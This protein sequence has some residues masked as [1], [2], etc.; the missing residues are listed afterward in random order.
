MSVFWKPL[1]QLKVWKWLPSSY[2]PYLVFSKPCLHMKYQI[3]LV[4]KCS[5][6]YN[7]L[8]E[9]LVAKKKYEHKWNY[10]YLILHKYITN[11]QSFFMH[12]LLFCVHK[13]LLKAWV[14]TQL[15]IW[16]LVPIEECHLFDLFKC[17]FLCIAQ[18]W[19]R[20]CL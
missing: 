2:I 12:K 13:P 8:T 7:S 9:K 14:K 3:H 16:W 1:I 15:S 6:Y 5:S 10:I 11:F 4:G 19:V 20:H 17:R 18:S